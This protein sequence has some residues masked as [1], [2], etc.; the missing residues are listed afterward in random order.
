MPLGARPNNDIIW[1]SLDV[2]KDRAFF[3]EQSFSAG[4]LRLPPWMFQR[5]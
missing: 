2:W 1:L 5:R 4:T 3:N